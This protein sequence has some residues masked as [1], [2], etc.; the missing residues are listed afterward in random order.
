[1]LGRADLPRLLSPVEE[2]PKSSDK[3]RKS[4]QSAR[5]SSCLH[6]DLPWP[7]EYKSLKL[8]RALAKKIQDI[9]IPIPITRL[10]SAK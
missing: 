6:F 7:K 1:M 8:P 9:T 4:P 3:A 10:C 5:R 2:K